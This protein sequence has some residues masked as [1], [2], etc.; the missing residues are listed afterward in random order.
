HPNIKVPKMMSKVLSILS[1]PIFFTL[2]YLIS[3][4]SRYFLTSDISQVSQL[5]KVILIGFVAMPI[6][7]FL[8]G[9]FPENLRPSF[10]LDIWRYEKRNAGKWDAKEKT[11]AS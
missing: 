10:Y 7:A 8:I 2:I 4:G 5:V 9:Y 11:K 1:L 3:N 6:A